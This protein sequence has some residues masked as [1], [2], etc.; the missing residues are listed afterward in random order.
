[1]YLI[2]ILAYCAF[3]GP[4]NEQDVYVM[5]VKGGK[6]VRLTDAQEASTPNIL[7]GLRESALYLRNAQYSR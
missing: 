7:K 4:D 6:E 5:P 3:R 1:M 2:N